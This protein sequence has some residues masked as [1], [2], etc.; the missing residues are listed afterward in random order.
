[1]KNY[2]LVIKDSWCPL[3]G[4][5]KVY[6]SNLTR[7]KAEGVENVALDLTH[8]SAKIWRLRENNI[9]TLSWSLP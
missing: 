2:V 9:K 3:D 7:L 5:C 1:M 4:D 6:G 8:I